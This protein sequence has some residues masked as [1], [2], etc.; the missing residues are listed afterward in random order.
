M[1]GTLIHFPASLNM[2]QSGLEYFASWVEIVPKAMSFH[3][4]QRIIF[5]Q[6]S[7]VHLGKLCLN[8]QC[9]ENIEFI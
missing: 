3:V 6:F 8:I 9:K 7:V 2:D 1:D 5:F 4:Y